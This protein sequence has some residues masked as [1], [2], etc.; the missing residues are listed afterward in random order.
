VGIVYIPAGGYTPPI[1]IAGFKALWKNAQ[2]K[3][4]NN[5]IS[6]VMNNINPHFNPSLT[7]C[8]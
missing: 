8:V 7:A 6:D 5:I 3:P 2:K 1:S 4:K